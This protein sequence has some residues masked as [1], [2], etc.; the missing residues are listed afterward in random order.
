MSV[1]KALQANQAILKAILERLDMCYI[2]PD[3][4]DRDCFMLGSTS[5]RWGIWGLP[6][7]DSIAWHIVTALIGG[8]KTDR[9]VIKCP[10][11][12]YQDLY[13]HYKPTGEGDLIE[14]VVPEFVNVQTDWGNIKVEPDKRAK[15]EHLVTLPQ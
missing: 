11:E 7:P 1:E 15:T 8:V 2:D 12:K 3:G 13:G 5:D 10:E 14:L 6:K 9:M 4:D